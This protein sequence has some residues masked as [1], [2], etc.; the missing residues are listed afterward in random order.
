M[1]VLFDQGTPAPLRDSLVGH[2][3]QTAY[4]LGWSNFKNGALLDAAERHG[5]EVLIITD[6]ALR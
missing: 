6:Q 4:E 3:V 1:R 5:Y 2:T